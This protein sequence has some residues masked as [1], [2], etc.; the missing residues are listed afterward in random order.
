MLNSCRIISFGFSFRFARGPKMARGGRMRRRFRFL[1]FRKILVNI[2]LLVCHISYDAFRNGFIF[3][4]IYLN[5]IF[6]MDLAP[7]GLRLNQII[8]HGDPKFMHCGSRLSLLHIP[9]GTVVYNLELRPGFGGQLLRAAGMFGILVAKHLQF[10]FAILRFRS[11]LRYKI[12]LECSASIGRVS[13][14]NFN[15]SFR[16]IAGYYRRLGKRPKVRGVAKNPVDHP[17]GGRTAGGKVFRNI[18]GRV[19]KN[20]K[21][22]K[23]KT[24]FLITNRYIRS[25]F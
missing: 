7:V 10:N 19:L 11:G 21:T 12:C 13:N 16:R 17:N 1:F 20:R 14:Y 22:N 5:G 2:P 23:Y 3:L 25:L 18:T 8:V 6:S 24:K 15:I 9:I 4:G